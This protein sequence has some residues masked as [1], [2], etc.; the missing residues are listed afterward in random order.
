[1]D[2]TGVHLV[3]A[4][5]WTYHATGASS[6]AV[7]GAEDKR[8]ITA[9]IASSLDGSLLP[10]QLIFQGKTTRTLPPSTAEVV[11]SRAH[12]TFSD[13]HWSNQTTM[14]DYIEKV[15]LP[16]SETR[17]EL[18]KLDADASSILVLDVWSVHK[19]EEFR[20]FLRTK[21]PR[22][23]LVYIPPNCT[24]KLQVADVALQRPF[25]H[26]ITQ[27]FNEWA[28]ENVAEQIADGKVVGLGAAL[29]MSNIKPL[30][31]Q[32]CIES[33]KALKE[34]KGLILDGWRKCVTSLYNVNSQQKRIDA[35]TAIAEKKLE[36]SFLPDEEEQ[37]AEEESD[38]E[39]SS[40]DE[41]DISA[42]RTF[43]HQGTRMRTPAKQFGYQFA[44]SQIA[45]TEDSE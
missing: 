27:Q 36:L 38:H 19:S 33:W 28:G 21:H 37:D 40:N 2:Q 39:D 12:I 31:L 30:A 9:C 24:S 43:G 22:I 6:V 41:L 11:A 35:L 10:L 16:Y 34:R 17:I 45:M 7:L 15:I 3:P 23:H 18:F 26:I 32:W 44:S 29:K 4:S 25:K 8:Q 5:N 20:R 13:N 1:M 42:P 14:Q